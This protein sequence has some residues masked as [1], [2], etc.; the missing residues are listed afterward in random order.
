MER[1]FECPVC[2][3]QFSPKVKP[4][5][6]PCGHTVCAPC[7]ENL[8]RDRI[9]ECPVCRTP[10]HNLNLSALSPNYALMQNENVT[11]TSSSLEDKIEDLHKQ[12]SGLQNFQ[13]KVQDSA[14]K[15][16]NCIN[17]VK[18]ELN[19][20]FELVNGIVAGFFKALNSEVEGIE[21]QEAEKGEK[22]CMQVAGMIEERIE[23]MQALQRVLEEKN[24]I[25]QNIKLKLASASVSEVSFEGT[26]YQLQSEELDFSDKLKKFFGSIKTESDGIISL[27][28]NV[29]KLKESMIF[30]K[31][32]AEAAKIP[33]NRGAAEER[34]QRG[35]FRGAGRGRGEIRE[36]GKQPRQ[37][38]PELS[39]WYVENRYKKMEKLQPW[40]EQQ[41]KEAQERGEPTVEVFESGKA[42]YLVNFQ[43]MKSYR[44][45]FN[46][47]LG[48]A[49]KLFYY[50]D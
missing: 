5:L 37:A 33:A 11:R 15:A 40:F 10:H 29:I 14:Y 41:L 30:A 49:L 42:A 18:N 21:A 25:P 39:G 16:K 3:D 20:K 8:K 45:K 35:A 17:K 34:G 12:I 27:E 47:K 28:S 50:P 4:L 32:E 48:A 31:P 13:S 38:R 36:E 22:I 9:I 19:H 1:S 26:S 24:E 43:E 46:K 6:I 44:L 23:I 7:L 2:F